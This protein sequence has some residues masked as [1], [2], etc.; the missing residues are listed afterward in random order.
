M[1]LNLV[2]SQEK[3]RNAIEI[4][5]LLKKE[6]KDMHSQRRAEQSEWENERQNFKREIETLQFTKDP[7]VSRVSLHLG[8][9]ML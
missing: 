7:E 4:K 9:I 8:D 1:S 3:L 6:V 5:K 2:G